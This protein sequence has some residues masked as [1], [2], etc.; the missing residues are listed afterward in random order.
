MAHNV[1]KEIW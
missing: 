1:E